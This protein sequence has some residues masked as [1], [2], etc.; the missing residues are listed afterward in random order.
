MAYLGKLS[1]YCKWFE[2]ILNFEGNVYDNKK[3][4]AAIILYMYFRKSKLVAE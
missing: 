2:K 4:N 1:K 3:F